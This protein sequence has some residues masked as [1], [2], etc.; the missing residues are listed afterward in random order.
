NRQGHLRSPCDL[1]LPTPLF[2]FKFDTE[3]GGTRCTRPTLLRHFP[4][5]GKLFR[6]KA[7]GSEGDRSGFG[8]LGYFLPYLSRR[9]RTRPPR[10]PDATNR[11]VGETIAAG[12]ATTQAR[13][14]YDG[15][16]IVLEFDG[17]GSGNLTATTPSHRYLWGPAVDQLLADEQVTNGDLLVWALGDNEN[18]VRDLA[19][20]TSGV[21]TVVNHRVFSSYGQLLSQTNPG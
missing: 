9:N 1:R 3:S 7:L 10:P 4:N 18:T 13:Y 19:T 20:Y 21:T 12:S 11:W 16:Q 6:T 2:P 5:A 17:T 15:N 8:W 14:I